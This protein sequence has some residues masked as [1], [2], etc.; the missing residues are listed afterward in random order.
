M[1]MPCLSTS[2]EFMLIN[3]FPF[4]YHWRWNE[5]R[6]LFL[7]TI[8]IFRNWQYSLIEIFLNMN[9]VLCRFIYICPLI[10]CL[11]FKWIYQDLDSSEGR[12]CFSVQYR[13][14]EVKLLLD[15]INVFHTQRHVLCILSSF[16]D[17]F[18]FKMKMLLLFPPSYNRGQLERS[19]EI[20]C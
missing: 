14:K 9:T 8:S 10:I 6:H 4:R 1:N 11:W 17:L 3:S 19:D 18:I 15:K 2:V 13:R 5:L 16:K 20:I 12:C 7:C